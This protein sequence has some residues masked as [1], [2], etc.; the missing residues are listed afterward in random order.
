MDIFVDPCN[1]VDKRKA[2]KLLEIQYERPPLIG[3]DKEAIFDERQGRPLAR[4]MLG[5]PESLTDY[6]SKIKS[7]LKQSRMR[8]KMIEI[9]GERQQ[10]R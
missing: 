10:N 4:S 6:A 7:K 5:P 1:K 9:E 2:E 8:M 3:E